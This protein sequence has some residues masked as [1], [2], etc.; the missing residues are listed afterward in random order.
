VEAEGPR[1]LERCPVRDVREVLAEA[2]R[3]GDT[4]RVAELTPEQ[5]L[6]GVEA[7]AVLRA[8]LVE[9]A[10]SGGSPAQVEVRA[11]AGAED[12]LLTAAEVAQVLRCS[13]PQVYRQ[14][15][16]WQFTRKLSHRVLR[17]SEA[18][19]RVWLAKLSRH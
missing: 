13:V 12:R 8:V 15:R 2:V 9:R 1:A 14:A 18:G 3:V 6:D 16:R 19:L 5:A 17:F 11:G 4:A 7:L 10:R